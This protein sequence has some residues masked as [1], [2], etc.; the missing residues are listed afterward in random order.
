VAP[1]AFTRPVPTTGVRVLARPRPPAPEARRAPVRSA[2]ATR[3]RP[4]DVLRTGSP[5]ARAR[6][7]SRGG[8]RPSTD[9]SA[10]HAPPRPSTEFPTWVRES[11]DI[12][13]PALPSPV[14][15]PTKV[16][17]TQRVGRVVHSHPQGCCGL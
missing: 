14:P 3:R 12:G 2:R 6:F 15:K 5:P 10:P 17:R 16:V 9:P 1:G 4:D 11:V 8:R 13:P 7:S